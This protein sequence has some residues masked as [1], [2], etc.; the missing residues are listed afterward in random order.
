LV[1]YDE[2][3]DVKTVKERRQNADRQARFK[4]KQN[5]SG[6]S[7]GVTATTIAQTKVA[8]STEVGGNA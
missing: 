6:V 4:A 2:Y 1:N 7:D 8:K 5:D 3:A